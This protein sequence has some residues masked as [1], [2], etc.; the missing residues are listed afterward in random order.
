M[1]FRK[2]NIDVSGFNNG[3]LTV[4]ATQTDTA[5]NASTA[6]SESITLDNSAPSALTITTP[7]E[8]DGVVNAVED[9]DVLIAGTGA[10]ANNSVT[11]AISDGANS[12]NRTVTADNTG[13]WTISGSEFDVSTF[14]NGTLTVTVSQSD[15]AGNTSSNATATIELDNALPSTATVAI[16]QSLIDKDNEN[17]LSFGLANLDGEGTID[18]EITGG[19]VT[20]SYGSVAITGST[21]QVNNVDVTLFAEGTLALSV[22]VTDPSG[23][24]AAA[25]TASVL[26]SYNV[27]PVLSGTPAAQVNE[28][29]AYSFTPTLTDPDTGDSHTFSITNQ[30]SW[31]AFDTATGAL[32]GTPTNDDVGTTSNISIQVNDGRDNS[33]VITFGIEV[34]NVN[35]AP[36]V[37]DDTASTDEDNAVQVA[38]LT[39]DTD[40]DSTINP[41]S[42]T[43]GTAAQHGTTSVDTVTGVITYTPEADFNGTDTFTY[44]VED[45]DNA[46]S[47]SATVTITVN[48]VNDAPEAVND[49]ASTPEDNA[50]SID[51]AAND[52]DKDEGDSVDTSTLVIVS[53]ASN[54]VVA[55]SGGQIV[56]TPNINFNGTD[57][58]TYTIEDENGQV[59]NT[60]TVMVNV[61]GVNDLPEAADDSATTDEDTA[62]AVDVL[63]NDSDIDGTVDATTV[64]IMTNPQNGSAS[65]DA[66]TGEITYTPSADYNGSDSFT[67]VVQDDADGTS[68]EATVAITINSVNDAP[69]AEDNTATLLEDTPHTINVLGNDSD[70]DG[71]ID[72]SSVAVVTQPASGSVIVDGS[73][74]ISYT[75]SINFN[76]SDSF[77]YTVNDSDGAVSNTATVN[78]TVTPVNDEPAL[79]GTPDGLVDEDGSYSFTPAGSDVDSDDSLT[80]TAENLPS[81]ANIDPETG[82]ITGT[83]ANDDVGVFRDI[84]VSVSDGTTTTSLPAFSLTVANTNDAP[85]AVADSYTTTEGG[86]LQTTAE[87][88]VLANDSDE[89]ASDT[90]TATLVT[91]PTR[92]GNFTLN[93]DGSF[94]YRHNGTETRSDSFTY[95]LSD[96]T[97]TLPATTVNFTVTAVNDAPTF[98]STPN[99][100]SVTQ[101]DTYSYSIQTKDTD[102]VTNLAL[103]TGPSW[104]RLQSG[105][106]SGTAP[107]SVTGDQAITLTVEDQEFA[108]TQNYTLTVAEAE[109]TVVSMA[110]SWVGLPLTV[111]KSAQL[112]VTLTHEQG[113]ELTSGELVI[114]FNANGANSQVAGCTSETGGYRCAFDLADGASDAFTLAVTPANAGDLVMN[115]QVRD[116][117]SNEVLT[118]KITDVSVQPAAVQQSNNQFTLANATALASLNISED[119]DKELIAGTGLGNDVKLLEYSANEATATVFGTIDNTGETKTLVVADVDNDNQKDVLVINTEGDASTLYY[120]MGDTT[121]APDAAS[122][123]LPY[124]T[125][126]V[127]RDLNDDDLPE[128][129]LGG[130]GFNLYVYQNVNGVFSQAPY[131][132]TTPASV[133]HFALL[134]RVPNSA[135]LS[136]TLSFASKGGVPCAFW[137]A[138]RHREA[139]CWGALEGG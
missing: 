126:G 67:Y 89:D 116:A 96:G 4:S 133:A 55:V 9:S 107:Y 100:L 26:K 21:L 131:V 25:V 47:V 130:E 98:V 46:E 83:P 13:A 17:A 92:A 105:T 76:G 33:N 138:S 79:S 123:D 120:N 61:T 86:I 101:G 81:W 27:A 70:V 3:T 48:T 37:V 121:F 64:I 85:V 99:I 43:V 97:V 22:V 72:S 129:I 35:D 40:V 109:A 23:N 125:H 77:T 10:E 113:P 52:S 38:V 108:I 15:S 118:R 50:V 90:L 24:A 32:T 60:A 73:G 135:P 31:A 58:F 139:I 134:K 80:Y 84:I 124:A 103:T 128:L 36:T 54:G 74:S 82:E 53:N 18:Y 49:T 114:S 127:L 39:N 87:T 91:G 12:L 6:A 29:T 68:N 65:V 45:L 102:S 57:S 19:G 115:L 56:Y 132:F 93:E 122:Q 112:A 71:T 106:L 88:G 136:G 104:L 117:S 7:I 119:T 11:V 5:G 44:T 69:V 59:S 30:P 42:L 51:V 8:S 94:S 28:D 1:I 41:A 110:T 14:N 20:V 62:V 75:P 34:V 63:A 66:L 16:T 111:G 137:P 78:I 95:A 2:I